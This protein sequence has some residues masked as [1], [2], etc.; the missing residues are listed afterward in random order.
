[1]GDVIP[2][3]KVDIRLSDAGSLVQFEPL[4]DAA[5]EW[6]SEFVEAEPYM[7]LGNRLCVESRYAE[8]ISNAMAE[9]GLVVS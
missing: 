5:K 1:M 4:T 3:K 2:F 6:I 7:W 9:A 8:E